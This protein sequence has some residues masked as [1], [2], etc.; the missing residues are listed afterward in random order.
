[1]KTILM[2]TCLIAGILTI[3]FFLLGV[4]NSSQPNQCRY[5]IGHRVATGETLWSIAHLYQELQDKEI[6]EF[7]F[8][9]RQY[10][11]GISPI[12]YPG[13]LIEIPVQKTV[14]NTYSIPNSK[15]EKQ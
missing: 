8:D 15:G 11:G 7:I 3:A 5:V 9:I 4:S 14:E 1:M 13:Q 12:I 6:R 10:N 2:K